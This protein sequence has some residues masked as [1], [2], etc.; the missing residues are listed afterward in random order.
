MFA[1]LVK[2][3]NLHFSERVG[4]RDCVLE[5]ADYFLSIGEKKSAIKC[6]EVLLSQQELEQ[7]RIKRLYSQDVQ[8]EFLKEINQSLK[9]TRT[10]LSKLLWE[11]GLYLDS[12]ALSLSSFF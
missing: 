7:R 11:K 12:L 3:P 10:R 6:Y 2:Y 8:L 5:L 4:G 9:E 1:E